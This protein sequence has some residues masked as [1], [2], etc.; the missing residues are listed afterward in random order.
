M[1]N[2]LFCLL[3]AFTLMLTGISSRCQGIIKNNKYS[4]SSSL[5]LSNTDKLP[6]WLHANQYGEVPYESQFLQLKGSVR[7]EYDSLYTQ[8]KTLNKFSY[9]YGITGLMNVGKVNQALLSE[10]YIKARHGYFEIYA[11]RRKEIVGLVDSTLSSGSFIW[12]GNALPIPKVQISTPNYVPIIGDGLVSIKASFAHGWFGS[13]D[14]VQNYYL[15]QKTFYTRIGKPN[16][17][18][19]FYGGFNH[20][21]QWGGRPTIPWYD[22]KTDQ[23]ITKYPANLKTY[24]NVVSGLS[25][26][27]KLD[28]GLDKDGIPFNEAFN[29][30]G[31]H[32]GT[33]DVAIEFQTRIGIILLY[34]QS[35][36]EDGSLFYLSNI[37]DGLLGLTLS[38]IVIKNSKF[39]VSKINFEYLDSRSQGGKGGSGNVIPELRGQDNYFNNSLY[40]DGWTYKSMSLANSYFIPI[41]EYSSL[42]PNSSR[43]N[44]STIL[45]SRLVGFNSGLQVSLNDQN[46][47]ARFSKS[48]NLGNYAFELDKLSQQSV[49]LGWNTSINNYQINLAIASDWGEFLG[50]QSSINLG[51]TWNLNQ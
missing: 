34:R 31:N 32:L 37:S 30:A 9:G 7:H 10:G 8:N 23:I 33:V 28:A 41:S 49:F 48:I 16:W 13:T 5:F 38:P 14:S 18:F 29:R 45:N 21:V 40:E 50:N 26:N 43:I 47:L 20:Q 2:G 44:S 42:V 1:R 3:I 12:S 19:K 17:K 39:K 22:S 11:G 25:L 35:I 46:I 36:Y 4:V 24:I 6:F 15:H 27:R 51:L